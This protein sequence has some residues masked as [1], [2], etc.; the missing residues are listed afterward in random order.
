MSKKKTTN[1]DSKS[2]GK[3]KC[4]KSCIKSKPKPK[5]KNLQDSCDNAPKIQ[6]TYTLWQKIKNWFS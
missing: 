6:T 5:S 1:N 4:A 3:K 2:C